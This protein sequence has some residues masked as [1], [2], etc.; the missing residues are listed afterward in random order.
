[1]YSLAAGTV[2]TEYMVIHC[3]YKRTLRVQCTVQPSYVFV[4][5]V[6]LCKLVLFSIDCVCV[7]RYVIQ[8]TT[9][10]TPQCSTMNANYLS[11]S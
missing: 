2:G 8:C 10:A 7:L 3:R 4:H 6:A 5:C 9:Y 1:M 11:C